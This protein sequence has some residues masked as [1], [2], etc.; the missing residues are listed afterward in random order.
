MPGDVEDW[1]DELEIAET[2][3]VVITKLC[4][5]DCGWLA[6]YIRQR[7]AEECERMAQEVD[8]ELRVYFCVLPSS[9]TWT[10]NQVG[11]QDIFPPRVI[12]NFRVVVVKDAVIH[13]KPTNR[14]AQIT[15]WD[16]LSMDQDVLAEGRR[17]WVRIG[18]CSWPAPSITHFD[19][20]VTN[21]TPTS[22]GSWT[23]DTDIYLS[24]KRDTRWQRIR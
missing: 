20:K 6:Q 3:S 17:F 1:F 22:V 24:T 9:L 19:Y 10:L 18:F 2:P 21:L 8:S 11:W 14:R 4:A 16:V 12:R 7:C 23:K 15:A 13:R 5:K